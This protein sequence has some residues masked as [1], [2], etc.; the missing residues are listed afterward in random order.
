MREIRRTQLEL[1][2]IT[3]PE[4]RRLN[5]KKEGLERDLKMF[6]DVGDTWGAAPELFQ[7]RRHV[8][9]TLPP[10]GTGERRA[11][12]IR[13]EKGNETRK[14]L[15]LGQEVFY[16]TKQLMGHA[17]R[18]SPENIT[19]FLASGTGVAEPLTYSNSLYHTQAG[20]GTVHV[21]HFGPFG[22]RMAE[23]FRKA[24]T[25]KNLV[26][27]DYEY[28][29]A[30]A[31]DDHA[32]KEIE[33]RL[34]EKIKNNDKSSDTIGFVHLET[35]TA[36]EVKKVEDYIKS[37]VQLYREKGANDPIIVVDTTSSKG[38]DF[39][40]LKGYPVMAYQGSAKPVTAEM[41]MGFVMGTKKGWDAYSKR[42]QWLKVAKKYSERSE[43]MQGLAKKYSETTQK[44]PYMLRVLGLKKAPEYII[45]P[46]MYT[47]ARGERRQQ[48]SDVRGSF[49]QSMHTIM[50][51]GRNLLEYLNAGYKWNPKAK[52][53]NEVVT[54]AYR[55]MDGK[56]RISQEYI[57]NAL[58]AFGIG[59]EKRFSQSPSTMLGSYIT[60]MKDENGKE[61][62]IAKELRRALNEIYV[63]IHIGYAGKKP[64][65]WLK[66]KA[67]SPEN[68]NRI[69]TYW[70]DSIY[71]T[72]ERPGTVDR[73]EKVVKT[74]KTVAERKSLVLPENLNEKLA[75]AKKIAERQT[76]AL[77][78][79]NEVWRRYLDAVNKKEQLR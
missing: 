57:G 11:Y 67:G 21:L 17:F 34:E 23:Q 40:R 79:G 44:D 45:R 35:G 75:E 52:D 46:N 32:W 69:S 60:S 12:Q 13:N 64:K 2:Q 65:F 68:I 3:E 70:V 48:N 36:A 51:I 20:K 22:A 1:N 25:K 31:V 8:D 63:D 54:S 30:P 59:R 47:D 6:E 72:A 41:Q 61:V 77:E 4:L 78:K 66:S 38:L 29:A 10:L 55:Y 33:K 19:A 24:S 53:M 7:G 71:G 56:R 50:D 73:F 14:E 62:N 42:M 9:Q 74:L 39:E 27:H 5:E 43:M 26:V 15:G 37:L 28:G 16:F 76:R 58:D 49:T 18:L